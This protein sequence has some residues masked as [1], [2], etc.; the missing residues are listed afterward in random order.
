MNADIPKILIGTLFSEV[1]DYGI[2][3]WFK[4]VCSFTYPT[5]DI[6]MVDNSKD[7]KYH[8]KILKY[9]SE[10]KKKS[11]IGKLTILHA[12]RIHKKSEVF[13][14]FSANELRK[15]FLRYNYDCL[16]NLECDVFPPKDIIER[17]LSYNKVCIGATYF[18]GLKNRSYP[19]IVDLI[20]TNSDEDI[21][22]ANPPYLKGFYEMTD[23][24][25]PKPYF[26]QG[27][28]ICLIHRSVIEQVPFR[29]VESTFYDSV[30]F[31]DLF[32]NGIQN[33]LIPLI[34]RHENQ[35]WDIQRKLINSM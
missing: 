19:M 28:G 7:K 2:K 6:C 12:P 34:C 21:S 14:A 20:I 13:M 27:L 25:E 23:T 17:L 3:E 22:Y 35:D 11:N 33:Y 4:N 30:F 26:G 15:Y 18:S 32:N 1:K 31:A 29:A 24:F 8:K 9:F 5:F 10:H 16:L